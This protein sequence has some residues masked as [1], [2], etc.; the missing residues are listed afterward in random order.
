MLCIFT[1]AGASK[2]IL[3]KGMVTQQAQLAQRPDIQPGN[4]WR[5]ILVTN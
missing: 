2:C 5:G 4:G 3:K 1:T